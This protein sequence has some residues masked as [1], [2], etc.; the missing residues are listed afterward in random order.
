M[1]DWGTGFGIGVQGIRLQRLRIGLQGLR[2]SGMFSIRLQKFSM[3]VL[4]P[5]MSA[6]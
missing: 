6:L 1:K 2:M 3:S 5:S 4:E